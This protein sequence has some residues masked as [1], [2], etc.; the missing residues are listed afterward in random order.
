MKNPFPGARTFGK[1]NNSSAA[2]AAKVDIRRRV[3]EAVGPEAGVFDAFAGAGQL[4]HA[5]WHEAGHYVGCDKKWFQDE[6]EMF[7]ADNRR[8]LRSIDLSPFQIFDIDAYGLPWDQVVI[9]AARRKVAKGERIGFA[10]TD[11]TNINLKSGGIPISLGELAGVRGVAAQSSSRLLGAI[12]LDDDLLAW[13]I[14]GLASRMRCEVVDH[15]EAR[16]RTGAL[17]RYIG[18]VLVGR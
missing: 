10:I 9:I 18:L 2:K 16:G 12:R 6:R 14:K 1:I 11:G 7:A 8:V 4:Y 13:A 15:W 5:V 3:L 17:V